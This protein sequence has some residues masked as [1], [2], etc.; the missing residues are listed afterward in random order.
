[1][2]F[3]S[4]DLPEP[5][6]PTIPI[7]SRAAIDRDTLHNASVASGRYR[8]V[9]LRN[10]IAP[11]GGGRVTRLSGVSSGGALRIS[12]RRLTDT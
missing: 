5:D 11:R 4:V 9:T 1:M 8:I 7:T 3:V 2:S 12:P 10:S 6:G